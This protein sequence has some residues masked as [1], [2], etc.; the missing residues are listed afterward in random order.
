MY[1][2]SFLQLLIE[3]GWE[4]KAVEVHGGWLEID[5]VD[6]LEI[7]ETLLSNGDLIKFISL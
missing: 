3:A 2:T 4:V 5:S 6:D 1:M 7:Y